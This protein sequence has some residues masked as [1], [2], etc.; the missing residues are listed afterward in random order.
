[1]QLGPAHTGGDTVVWVPDDGVL[2]AGDLLLVGVSPVMWSGPI[3][4][5]IEACKRMEALQPSIVCAT[6]RR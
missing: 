5:W 2:F 3:E 6:P 4:G 1:M